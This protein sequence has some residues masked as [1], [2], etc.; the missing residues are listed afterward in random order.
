MTE[1][2]QKN[3]N[4]RIFEKIKNGQ[5]KMRPKLYFVLKSLIFA[6]GIVLASILVLFLFSFI[7]FCL[8][9]GGIWF[10][11]KFGFRG[12]G[13]FFISFPW[14]LILLALFLIFLLEIIAKKYSFV[15]KRPIIF[16]L[17]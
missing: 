8:K 12:L 13:I 16:S 14:F 4:D 1:Q 10:L 6:L 11:P 2:E 15:Y 17:I 7:V 3:I 9:L 5:V